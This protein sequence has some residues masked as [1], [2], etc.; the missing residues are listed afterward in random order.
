MEQK[1]QKILEKQ[2]SDRHVFSCSLKLDRP[3][4]GFSWEFAGGISRPGSTAEFTTDSEFFIASVTKMFTAA[5]VMQ[6]HHEKLLNLND[7][8]SKYIKPELLKYLHNFKGKDFS[9]QIT[10][11]HL[12]SNTSGLPDYFSSKQENG[13]TQLEILMQHGDRQWSAEDAIAISKKYQSPKFEPGKSGKAEYSDTN[14]QMLR[15]VIEQVIG[16]PIHPI[17]SERISQRLGLEHTYMYN[18]EEYPAVFYYKEK[19]LDIPLAMKSVTTDGGMVSTTVELNEFVQAF[20][21]GKLFPKEYLDQMQDWNR[22]FFPLQYGTGLMRFKLPMIFTLFKQ[23]PEMIGHS[24]VN[25][26]FAYYI[27]AKEAYICGTLN[28]I[29]PNS[30]AYKML[31]QVVGLL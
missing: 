19:P 9:N 23:L 24:G 5:V 6:L 27:P 7:S 30:K 4:K 10:I 29:Y 21:S 3:N 26:T 22:I 12:L 15:I 13:L 31:A 1:L 17:I 16:T 11:K 2:L 8:I 14:F 20:F 28:Q 18:G 25:G